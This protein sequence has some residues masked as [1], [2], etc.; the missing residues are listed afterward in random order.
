VEGRGIWEQEIAGHNADD[1]VADPIEKN[2]L[3]HDFGICAKAA[4][5]QAVAHH[6]HMRT[7]GDVLV[8]G[9]HTSESS[10]DLQQGKQICRNGLALDA[11]RFAAASQ[12]ETAVLD[13]AHSL[14]NGVLRLPVGEIPGRRLVLVLFIERQANF[15]PHHYQ[16][17][18]VGIGQAL[19]QDDIDDGENRGV[20]ADAER[21]SENS[22]GGE[23]RIL[24]E[25]AQTVANIGEKFLDGWP[26]PD[27]VA[28][29][30]NQS[31]VSKLA[32]SSR[33]G[34]LPRHAA[35]NQLLDLF[36]QVFPN[37]FRE[38]AIELSPRDQL[39][40]PVHD[41]PGP[42]TRVIPSSVRLKLDTSL[43]RCSS[44]CSKSLEVRPRV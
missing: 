35:R 24:A 34:F 40:R 15:F 25:H 39:L 14:K 11:R 28:V 22:D 44:I 43:S 37:L 30:F 42:K 7:A 3:V 8:G 1:G 21:Q 23:A 17:I 2:L 31:Y 4:D 9:E 29:L 10:I 36:L 12:I 19:K 27:L 33:C 16:T 20:G 41:S 18:S 6:D 38:F 5:P 26:S 13:G 32:T